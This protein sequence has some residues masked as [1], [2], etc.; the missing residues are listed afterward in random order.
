MV[1]E[2]SE[3][4]EPDT[5]KSEADTRKRESYLK[6]IILM[7]AGWLVLRSVVFGP[8]GG[9]TTMKLKWVDHHFY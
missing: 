2:I 8:L 5:R 7:T 4:S 1:N 9:A 3:H 6:L